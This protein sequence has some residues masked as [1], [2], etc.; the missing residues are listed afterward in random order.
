V[1]E[2]R[3]ERVRQLAR[4]GIAHARER[5][6]IAHAQER[7]GIAHAREEGG[8]RGKRPREEEAPKRAAKKPNL[9]LECRLETQKYLRDV[10]T[11]H[12]QLKKS[13]GSLR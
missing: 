7:S 6:V 13:I 5:G 8:E 1:A 9:D 3:Q 4:G 10:R 12:A 2:V 11:Q